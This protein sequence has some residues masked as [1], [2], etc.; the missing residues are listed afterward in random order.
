M[1]YTPTTWQVGDVITAEL[2][3]KMEQAIATASASTGSVFDTEDAVDFLCDEIRASL[4]TNGDNESEY[5]DSDLFSTVFDQNFDNNIPIARTIETS[6]HSF[7]VV[8]LKV[9]KIPDS[10]TPGEYLVNS[11]GLLTTIGNYTYVVT[12]AEEIDAE[13]GDNNFFV[14]SVRSNLVGTLALP[15]SAPVSPVDPIDEVTD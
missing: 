11:R 13:T 12:V 2:L 4:M 3:N 1:A 7:F 10:Q 9:E 6:D 15:E 8:Y 14:G 5:G